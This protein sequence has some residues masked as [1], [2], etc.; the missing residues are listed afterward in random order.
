M[1]PALSNHVIVVN[2]WG[3]SRRNIS[4]WL[5]PWLQIQY[6]EDEAKNRPIPDH[7]IGFTGI[8]PRLG[9]FET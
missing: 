4:A 7:A 9:P 8:L 3:R 2:G 1:I 5:R 6:G